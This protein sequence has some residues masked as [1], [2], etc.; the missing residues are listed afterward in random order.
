MKKHLIKLAI[1]IP[2]LAILIW[3]GWVGNFSFQSDSFYPFGPRE[4]YYSLVAGKKQLGFARRL[5]TLDAQTKNT[6]LSEDSLINLNVVIAEGE[7][8][9]RSTAVFNSSGGLLSSKLTIDLGQGGKPLAD[10]AGRI[11]AGELKYR[12]QIGERVRE[13]TK[14]IPETG[15]ILLS[16]LIPWLARQRELPLG[17]P[18]FFSLFDP[19]KLDFRPASLTIIE[20][21][22]QAEEKKVY[23]LALLLDPDQTEIWINADGQVLS[24]KASGLEFG[25]DV[26][27]NPR[28]TEQA[29]AAL[30]APPKPTLLQHI[31]QAFLDMIINQGV[32]ALWPEVDR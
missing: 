27:T 6:T 7:I 2:G 20:V 4:D 29:K 31:P 22:N 23:K 30:D 28:L 26:L 16:G 5:V 11:E 12:F 25:L 17:R 21:T 3:W 10:V 13:V 15:P 32:G 1:L 19:A 18:I 8:R 24:Q 14:P 9:C